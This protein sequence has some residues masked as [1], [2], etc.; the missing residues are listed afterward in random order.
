MAADGNLLVV[1]SYCPNSFRIREISSAGT[2]EILGLDVSKGL[3]ETEIEEPAGLAIDAQRDLYLLDATASVLKKFHRD[4]R[5]QDSFSTAGHD[6]DPL[7]GPRDVA[8]DTDG[9]LYIAD[10]NNDRIVKLRGDGGLEWVVADFTAVRN[11][12]E[13]DGFYEPSSLCLTGD[14]GLLVADTNQ[15]RLLRFDRQ[16]HFG[17]VFPCR[18]LEFPSRVRCSRQGDVYVVDKAGARIGRFDQTGRETACLRLGGLGGEAISVESSAG[19]DVDPEGHALMINALR[20][21][22]SVLAFLEI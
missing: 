7:D 15:N 5:W 22:V 17:G 6:D 10:T 9:H 8:V 14:D 4:G 18:E 11:G 3:G 1:E 21:S 2:A 13:E 16:G 19:F 12:R 20:E